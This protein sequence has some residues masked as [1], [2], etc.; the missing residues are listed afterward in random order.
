MATSGHLYDVT[1][2][3]TY[4]T[5]LKKSSFPFCPFVRALYREYS[6]GVAESEQN[7]QLQRT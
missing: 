5:N 1:K 6:L 2:D 7:G 3:E 4:L